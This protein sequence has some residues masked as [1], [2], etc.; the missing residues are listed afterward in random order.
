M[1]RRIHPLQLFPALQVL[2]RPDPER[3]GRKIPGRNSAEK[4]EGG[5]RILPRRM[6]EHHL[7]R[8]QAALGH[9]LPPLPD[10]IIPDP[11]HR[12][13]ILKVLHR[14][15]TEKLLLDIHLVQEQDIHPGQKAA[16]RQGM[17]LAALL[18]KK[19]REMLP[20]ALRNRTRGRMQ[21][22]KRRVK[23]SAC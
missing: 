17:N 6:P 15:R 16:L 11:Q 12:P 4:P 13:P 22:P 10:R 21:G 20:A 5:M 8:R 19:H 1:L 7:Q 3:A 2:R 14:E 9:F 23:M 18:P